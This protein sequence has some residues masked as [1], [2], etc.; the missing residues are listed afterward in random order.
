MA[1]RASAGS[2]SSGGSIK[3]VLQS[4]LVRKGL[5]VATVG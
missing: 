1:V 4:D 3:V 2:E 5:P